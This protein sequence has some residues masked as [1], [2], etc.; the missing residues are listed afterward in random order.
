MGHDALGNESDDLGR[1]DL[2]HPTAFLPKDIGD[3]AAAKFAPLSAH[4][5]VEMLVDVSG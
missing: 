1:E 4:V 2:W 3:G 5:E